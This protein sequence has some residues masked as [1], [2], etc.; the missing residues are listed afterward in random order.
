MGASSLFARSIVLHLTAMPLHICKINSQ[1]HK[2]WARFMN[3]EVRDN[4]GHSRGARNKS[5]TLSTTVRYRKFFKNTRNY[6]GFNR[7]LFDQQCPRILR[8]LLR[9]K[10]MSN[11]PPFVGGRVLP[12]VL[13]WSS[14]G[15]FNLPQ[16]PSH[17][18]HRFLN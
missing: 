17:S 2:H 15:F 10:A 13:H 8:T 3:N 16:M 6:W 4:C 18:P 9:K 7:V 14:M 5:V 1:V 12:R 11:S